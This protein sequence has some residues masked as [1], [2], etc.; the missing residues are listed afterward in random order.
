MELVEKEP[1]ILKIEKNNIS[2]GIKD[3]L[4]KISFRHNDS[5]GNEHISKIKNLF[6][7]ACDKNSLDKESFESFAD[8]SHTVALE[9]NHDIERTD[10]KLSEKFSDSNFFADNYN[11]I[12]NLYNDIK[13]ERLITTPEN[14]NMPVITNIRNDSEEKN[15][16]QFKLLSGN[17]KLKCVYDNNLSKGSYNMFGN[18][19]KNEFEEF[20]KTI[21]AI[22]SNIHT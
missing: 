7:K 1:Y 13:Y 12:K 18:V 17:N 16:T 14:K 3:A 5:L 8:I 19:S 20:L 15:L 6:V 10:I 11:Y 9:L 4:D 21:E 2:V 22:D